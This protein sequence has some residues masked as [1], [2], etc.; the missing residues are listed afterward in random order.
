MTLTAALCFVAKRIHAALGAQVGV[1]AGLKVVIVT[2][3][4]TG[5]I[6]VTR[7]ARCVVAWTAVVK[8]AWPTWTLAIARL[9]VAVTGRTII[10][11]W[12]TV[13]KLGA[14]AVACGAIAHAV[15]AHMAVGAG[16]AAL[17][18]ST[19]GAALT[20]TTTTTAVATAAC[21]F[22]VTNALQHF[23]AR[24]FG[25]GSHHVTAWGLA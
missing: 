2:T 7:C 1:G 4:C 13:I 25:S 8:L 20:T 16:C 17:C 14:F 5:C 22:G 18:I 21:G 3:R 15:T 6:K 19:F 9:A 23:T 24:C 12:W 10:A 11:A